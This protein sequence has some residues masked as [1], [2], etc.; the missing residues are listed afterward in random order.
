[1]SVYEPLS[2]EKHS[3]LLIDHSACLVEEACVDTVLLFPNEFQVAQRE[4]PIF[5]KKNTHT[6]QFYTVAL[7]GFSEGE[8]LFLSSTEWLGNYMPLVVAKGPFL[9]VNRD[10]E[11]SGQEQ[12][13]GLNRSHQTLSTVV[14]EPMFDQSGHLSPYMQS[15]S[16]VL[17]RIQQGVQ[18][19]DRFIKRLLD[20]DLIHAVDLVVDFADGQSIK[21]D[22]LFG[23][24]AD[25]LKGLSADVIAELHQED[26][27]AN[28][29]YLVA[30]YGNLQS[31]ID[32]RNA[33]L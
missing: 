8:N 30:S 14:G 18:Q 17:N 2:F 6:G 28:L 19:G 32:K 29:Y 25:A 31:L 7:V 3:H 10:N 11:Q 12:L 26:V 23:I 16:D 27:L 15:I 24:S 22:D 1:M 9:I 33:L 5:F 4:Y 20:L 13:I 21:R